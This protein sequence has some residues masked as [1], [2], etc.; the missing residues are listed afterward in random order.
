MTTF[1]TMLEQRKKHRNKRKDIR[2]KIVALI[3]ED[4]WANF[5]KMR[6]HLR[7]LN[8]LSCYVKEM[9]SA[10]NVSAIALKNIYPELPDENLKSLK[11]LK[12]AKIMEGLAKLILTAQLEINA[13]YESNPGFEELFCSYESEYLLENKYKSEANS[14][15]GR[16]SMTNRQVTFNKAN[17]NAIN[18]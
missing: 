9:D 1:E 16:R 18:K 10:R 6:D 15:T 8:L 13:L 12:P 17:H 3:S 7:N 2:D 4:T 11:N 14:M 5:T